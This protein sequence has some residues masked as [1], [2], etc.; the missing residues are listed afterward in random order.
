VFD[1]NGVLV[2]VYEPH[3]GR[4]KPAV[5]LAEPGPKPG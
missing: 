5:V 4:A 2:A 3:R 1:A